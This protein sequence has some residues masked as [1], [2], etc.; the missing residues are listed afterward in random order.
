LLRSAQP[1]PALLEL[2]D[3]ASLSAVAE[4]RKAAAALELELQVVVGVVASL[5]KQIDRDVR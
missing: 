3:P 5:L 1:Q 4:R 2:H